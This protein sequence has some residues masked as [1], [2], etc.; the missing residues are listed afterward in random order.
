MNLNQVNAYGDA[1]PLSIDS[2]CWVS[3]RSCPTQQEESCCSTTT[4]NAFKS[5]NWEEN[6]CRTPPTTT[7]HSVQ[8]ASPGESLLASHRTP[9][10][11]SCWTPS[12][13]DRSAEAFVAAMWS[14][15]LG[16]R[17]NAAKAPSESRSSKQIPVKRHRARGARAGHFGGWRGTRAAHRGRLVVGFDRSDEQLER[18]SA[19]DTELLVEPVGHCERDAVSRGFRLRTSQRDNDEQLQARVVLVA[20]RNSEREERLLPSPLT[21]KLRQTTATRLRAH[22]RA[23]LSDSN[24]ERARS[25]G[26]AL[27]TASVGQRR[28]QRGQLRDPLGTQRLLQGLETSPEAMAAA[29]A[30]PCSA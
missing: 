6:R 22:R 28:G 11:S 14:P 8:R 18:G 17:P 26:S 3:S 2:S 16:A 24:I 4:K 30:E 1:T 23:T 7:F 27:M 10:P 21:A 9:T 15:L 12:T 19:D 20:E 25:I 13:P 5:L 29:Q